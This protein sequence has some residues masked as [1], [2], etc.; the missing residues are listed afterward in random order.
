MSSSKDIIFVLRSVLY[1]IV[2]FCML[3][4]IEVGVFKVLGLI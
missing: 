4:T 3:M 1:T 2:G